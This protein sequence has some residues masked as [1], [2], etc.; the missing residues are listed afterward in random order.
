M[1]KF[2]F[3]SLVAAFLFSGCGKDCPDYTFIGS[4]NCTVNT[5]SG[6]IFTFTP[7]EGNRVTV[8]GFYGQGYPFI[9]E[10]NVNGAVLTVNDT[11]ITSNTNDFQGTFTLTNDGA[12]LSGSFTID[13]N[14]E[15]APGDPES[16]IISGTRI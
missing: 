13:F 14:I 11:F 12:T 4:Y 3:L 1:R 5:G 6:R 8:A 10:G 15:N 16:Y 7:I 2:I 9:V